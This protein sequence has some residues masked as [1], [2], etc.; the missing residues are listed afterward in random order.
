[1]QKL[2]MAALLT[3]STA[4]TAGWHYAPEVYASSYT[5][6]R[7]TYSNG[8]GSLSG[9]AASSDDSQY[10]SCSTSSYVYDDVA[11]YYGFCVA[12]DKDWN[13]ASCYT[14]DAGLI[15]SIASVNS[16]SIV[17]FAA[18]NGVCTNVYNSN[19]STAL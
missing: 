10:I 3:F 17:S 19:T 2:I 15:N 7:T 5:Y 16:T 13:S 8:Y 12:V 14:T 9:A 1:M 6:R 11:S 18:T 4:A